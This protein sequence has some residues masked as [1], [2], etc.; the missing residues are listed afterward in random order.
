MSNLA[1][2]AGKLAPLIRPLSSDQDGEL[3]AAARALSCAR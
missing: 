1:P 2:I 3:V